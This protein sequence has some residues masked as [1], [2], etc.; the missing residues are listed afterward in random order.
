MTAEEIA[1]AQQEIFELFGQNSIEI[2]KKLRNKGTAPVPSGGEQAKLSEDDM[3]PLEEDGPPLP[4]PKNKVTFDLRDQKQTEK[5]SPLADVAHIAE[6]LKEE[7]DIDVNEHFRPEDL[8]VDKLRWI[9]PSLQ[10]DSHDGKKSGKKG[11]QAAV[12]E[13]PL[14][15]V[16]FDFRGN[17]VEQTLSTP[18]ASTALYHHGDSPE[19]AGYN[20][21]EVFHL[22][23]SRVPSQRVISLQILDEVFQKVKRGDYP[24]ELCTSIFSAMEELNYVAYLRSALDDE[25]TTVLFHALSALRSLITTKGED[26]LFDQILFTSQTTCYLAPPP[27]ALKKVEQQENQEKQ[28][29]P[30]EKEQA[31]VDVVDA[32]LKANLVTKLSF[33]L[34][35][36][37]SPSGNLPFNPFQLT[38]HLPNSKS[39]ATP[40]TSTRFWT[41]S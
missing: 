2:L 36:M 31:T 21:G 29:T 32:L 7:L 26:A 3:P 34:T 1:A 24:D 35:S 17:I 12:E 38:F 6:K 10:N 41:C 22:L 23:R 15:R 25:S 13:H 20:I 16:R 27:K 5:K 37:S 9:I 28:D 11:D 4:A 40:R 8:E 19:D 30:G 39:T 14:A 18:S 33:I